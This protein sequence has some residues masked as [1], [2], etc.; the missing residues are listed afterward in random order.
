V[1]FCG[2]ERFWQELCALLDA[3]ELAEDPRFSTFKLRYQNREEVLA[4]IQEL[5]LERTTEEW[6]KLLQGKVPCAPV[7][8]IAQGLND[9]QVLARGMIVEVDHPKFGPLREVGSPIKIVGEEHPRA[10]AA[11][12][13]Q[14][15]HTILQ[16][17]LGYSDDDIAQL[18]AAGAI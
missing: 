16:E 13:G 17:E 2:K 15:T 7:N 12:L 14:D 18:R 8:T 3:P 11:P 4:L 1:L 6:V 5:L 10:P 9:P